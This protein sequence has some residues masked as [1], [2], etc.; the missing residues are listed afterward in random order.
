MK[1]YNKNIN[2]NSQNYFYNTENHL[3]Y[4]LK[5]YYLSYIYTYKPYK[6]YGFM[7]YSILKLCYC[8]LFMR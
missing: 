1:L 2:F 4:I 7:Q 8:Q 3:P 6:T 5:K